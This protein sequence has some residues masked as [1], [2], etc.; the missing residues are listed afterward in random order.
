V[1]DITDRN[2]H[3]ER[4][5]QIQRT[6]LPEDAPR[7]EGYELAAACRPA[8]DVAGDFYDWTVTDDRQVELTVADV[9]G[10]GVAAALVM[11]VLRTA[12][13][14]APADMSPAAQVGVAAGSMSLGA[15]DEGL[16]ATL[17]HAHLDV[18][19]GVLH[20]VDA[21]HGYCAIRRTTGEF[22]R[23]T[24]RS[25]PVGAL[26]DEGFR[27]GTVVLAPG[28]TLIVYSDGLVEMDER[29][30]A[31]DEFAPEF[32][33]ARAADDLVARLMA[34]ASTRPTD[35]V[36]VLVLRRLAEPA[37]RDEMTLLEGAGL[38]IALKCSATG[39]HLD[40]VHDALARFWSGLDSVPDDVWRMLFELAVAEVAANI[41]EHAHPDQMSLRLTSDTGSMIAEFTYEGAGWTDIPAAAPLE[42]MAERGRGLF[43]ARTG[44]DEMSYQRFGS[45]IHWRLIKRQ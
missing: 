18:A 9:M 22:I 17:F 31:L 24:V 2:R 39:E 44:V 41:I 6:L 32:N 20:Y 4:E 13:R 25:L 27:E 3:A 38:E 45:T 21:G 43:L 10:K 8:Q 37:R 36:T 30:L 19:T 26:N 1:E 35:D 15:Y 28:E 29:T 11:A 12:L 33:G 40:L 16:F 42:L 7:I 34:T 5:A 14:A 23:L